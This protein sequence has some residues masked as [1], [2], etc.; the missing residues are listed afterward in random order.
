M[1]RYQHLLKLKTV[2]NEALGLPPQDLR[3]L[4]FADVLGHEK[5]PRQHYVRRGFFRP[6]ECPRRS[7]LRSCYDYVLGLCGR[8]K[9]GVGRVSVP[10]AVLRLCR[11]TSATLGMDGGTW[12]LPP[13]RALLYS[14]CWMK[15]PCFFAVVHT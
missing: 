1:D 8:M 12:L 3:G 9:D 14:F 7:A 4:T 13:F 2:Y 11:E 5:N 15:S 10:F 6:A